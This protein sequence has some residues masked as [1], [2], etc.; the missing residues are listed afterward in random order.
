MLMLLLPLLPLP[1]PPIRRHGDAAPLPPLPPRYAAAFLMPPIFAFD[2]SRRCDAAIIFLILPLRHD[3]S[4]MFAA[5]SWLPNRCRD[6]DASRRHDAIALLPPYAYAAY[7]FFDAA[8]SAAIT[9]YFRRWH[10]RR[11]YLRCMMPPR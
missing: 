11:H 8:I 9:P 10:C 5:L 2:I 6:A 4:L 3:F 7:Y 1:L